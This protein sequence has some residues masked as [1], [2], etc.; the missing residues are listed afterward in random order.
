VPHLVA[1]LVQHMTEW[2]RRYCCAFAE[3]NQFGRRQGGEQVILP[4]L[5]RIDH[6]QIPT[7]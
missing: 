2:H 4:Q 5:A 6:D 1:G 7:L 3:T